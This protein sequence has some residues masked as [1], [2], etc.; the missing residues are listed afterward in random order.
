MYHIVITRRIEIGVADTRFGRCSP[1]GWFSIPSKWTLVPACA[2][3]NCGCTFFPVAKRCCRSSKETASSDGPTPRLFLSHPYQSPRLRRSATPAVS[4]H[5]RSARLRRP[6][7]AWT[8]ASSASRF[9]CWALQ[10]TAWQRSG[11][12]ATPLA[13]ALTTQRAWST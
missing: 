4:P 3:A 2:F 7:S 10:L 12:G 6:G 5:V 9:G 1:M 8:T 11:A 13:R